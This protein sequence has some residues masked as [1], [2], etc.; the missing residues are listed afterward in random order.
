MESCVLESAVP[1][2]TEEESLAPP[3][4]FE[5][6]EVLRCLKLCATGKAPHPNGFT[7]GFFINCWDVVEQDIMDTCQNFYD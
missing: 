1:C 7:S 2:L 5:E 3:D 4:N 6:N